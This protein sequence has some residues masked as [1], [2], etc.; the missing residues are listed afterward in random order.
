MLLQG[1]WWRLIFFTKGNLKFFLLE[2]FVQIIG[3]SGESILIKKQCPNWISYFYGLF[4]ICN[5]PSLLLKPIGEY[6]EANSKKK[7]LT[8]TSFQHRKLCCYS[9]ASRQKVD[10]GDGGLVTVE[11]AQLWTVFHSK[12]QLFKNL[13]HIQRDLPCKLIEISRTEI[14]K[15]EIFWGDFQNVIDIS[16]HY[17]RQLVPN[18][19]YWKMLFKLIKIYFCKMGQNK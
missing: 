17:Q 18:N 8:F 5:L 9:K 15:H 6:Y 16:L 12:H 2:C 7:K 3:F 1:A 11:M 13:P 14:F 19:W 10:G 4:M